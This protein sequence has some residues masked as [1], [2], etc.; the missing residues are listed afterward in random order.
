MIS[1]KTNLTKYGFDKNAIATL[2][3]AIASPVFGGSVLLPVGKLKGKR[4]KENPLRDEIANVQAN[5]VYGGGY[6]ILRDI[7]ESDGSDTFFDIFLLTE[8][9][10]DAELQHKLKSIHELNSLKPVVQKKT[11]DDFRVTFDEISD[12][13]TG[14]ARIITFVNVTEELDMSPAYLQILKVEEGQ[15]EK[16]QKNGY[17]RTISAE[18]GSC[19]V[20]FFK[21]D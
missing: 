15:F 13:I 17:C 20:G 4:T 2:N 19:E 8:S 14:Y 11:A 9:I 7:Q 21:D 5:S 6:Y 3:K 10:E 16:G 1:S 12:V 18:D